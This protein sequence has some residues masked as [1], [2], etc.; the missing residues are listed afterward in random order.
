MARFGI[1]SENTLGISMPTLRGIAR[2][3]G[4]DQSLA[5]ALWSRGIF[6]ARLLAS[7]IDEPASI[8]EEQL[9][10]WAGAFDSWAICDGCCANLFYKTPFAWEKARTWSGRSEEFV[11]RAGF[12]LMA[13]LAVHDKK[14]DD[15][16]FFPFLERIKEEGADERNFVKKA[17]NWA[18]RQIGKRSLFLNRAAIESAAA[19]LYGLL[20]LFGIIGR[21]R[22]RDFL[23]QKRAG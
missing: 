6:E 11:K 7:L 16:K 19:L 5:L 22:F 4:K 8:N 10:A 18:L 20:S 9:E 21:K 17:V 2:E 13:V 15:E 1:D 14:A 23:R 3:T 12:T